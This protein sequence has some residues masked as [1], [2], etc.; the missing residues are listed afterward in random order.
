MDAGSTMLTIENDGA[1]ILATNY[2]QTEYARR[3]IIYLSV[4]ARCFRLLLPNAVNR[5]LADMRTAKEVIV[6]RG[7]WPEVGRDDALEMMFEDLSDS[8]FALHL[9]RQQIDT[10]PSSDDD[11]RTDLKCSVWTSGPTKALEL[12]AKYR[13]VPAIPHMKPWRKA[14]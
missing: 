9:S 7:P 11:G 2:W 12:P 3:G 5:F 1:E 6:S 8:P 4:N 10:M 13:E 14:H